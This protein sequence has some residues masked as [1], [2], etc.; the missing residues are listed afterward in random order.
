MTIGDKI[1]ELLEIRGMTQSE[2]SKQSGISSGLI[3]EYVSNKRTE[4]TVNT[5]RRI[6]ETLR[7]HPAYFLEDDTI[8]PAD[9]LPHLTEEER[10]FVLNRQKL[11]WVKIAHAADKKGLA[12]AKIRQIIDI[13]LE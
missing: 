13:I 3:S 6:A 10:E 8:G 2:L 4:M 1:K 12:P 7:I 5:L 11:P 9:M